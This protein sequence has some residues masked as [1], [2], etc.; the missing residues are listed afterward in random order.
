[1]GLRVDWSII[2][3]IPSQSNCWLEIRY[4]TC[5][6]SSFDSSNSVFDNSDSIAFN[7]FLQGLSM[8][9]PAWSSPITPNRIAS[10]P[11]F[12]KPLATCAGT[13][14]LVTFRFFQ[15]WYRSMSSDCLHI[16]VYLSILCRYQY[17]ITTFLD[18]SL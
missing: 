11:M 2:L 6:H 14:V 10:S 4:S 5:D 18:L 9:P 15:N 1:M 16:R 7:F 13:Y 12:S 8:F 3:N 17:Y